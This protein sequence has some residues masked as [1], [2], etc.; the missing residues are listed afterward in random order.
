M[1][2]FLTNGRNISRNE[3]GHTKTK[4]LNQR[5]CLPQFLFP[6]PSAWSTWALW[7]WNTCCRWWS[8]KMEGVWV[9]TSPAITQEQWHGSVIW[10]RNSG[11][12]LEFWGLPGFVSVSFTQ[13]Y[14]RGLQFF[15]TYWFVSLIKKKSEV[16]Q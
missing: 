11:K 1:W 3:A 9:F 7:P 2:H 13:L 16:K 12:P 4:E 10:V 14:K 15:L 8:H 5:E 6:F